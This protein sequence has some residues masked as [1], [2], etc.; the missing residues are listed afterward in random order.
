MEENKDTQTP[1]P[2][3]RGG[4]VMDIQ[5]PSARISAAPTPAQ[6]V[7]P[8][9]A[10][11]QPEPTPTVPESEPPKPTP[12]FTEVPSDD[13]EPPK[14]SKP[15][16]VEAA[17]KES[18]ATPNDTNGDPA[19]TDHMLPTHGSH[20]SHHVVPIVIAIIV[21]IGLTSAAVFAY[22]KTNQKTDNHPETEHT[23]Q[24][25]QSTPATTG[26]VDD[27]SKQVD[28]TMNSANDEKDAPESDLSDQTLGL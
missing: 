6:A 27:A 8:A 9:S 11:T 20:K 15:F 24:P 21:A 2:A 3:A 7:D 10:P 4:G 17:L 16:D 22:I 18:G 19:K 12:V 25:T 1:T 26:D 23:T 28:D 13:P 14:P 5:R